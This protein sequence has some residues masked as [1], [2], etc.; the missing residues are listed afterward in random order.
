MPNLNDYLVWRGDISFDAVPVNE[1]DSLIFSLLA[2]I[3]F[4][5]IVPPPHAGG[6][7]LREAAKEYFFVRDQDP[8]RPLGLIVPAEIVVLFR[9]LSEMPR[10]RDLMLSGYVNEICEEREMQFSALTIHLS[11]DA[12]FVAFRG[13]DDTLVGWREDFNLS[14]MDE[15]PSQRKAADYLNDLDLLPDTSLW[16]GGHSKG[17]NLAVWGAVH[18]R[19]SV[20]RCVRRIWSNDG[21][22]F[23]SGTIQSEAYRAMAERISM[24]VPKDSLVGLILEHDEN[25]TVIEST[26]RGLLQH[27]ALSWEVQG[28]SFVRADSLSKRGLRSDT[29]IRDRLDAMTREEKRT[30]VRLFFTVL[31]ST[32]AKTLTDLRRTGLR[33][34]TSML[35]TVAGLSREEQET[36]MYLLGKLF[37][38]AESSTEAAESSK[39]S[40]P[41]AIKTEMRSRI[42]V[43]FG[44]CKRTDPVLS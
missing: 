12:V 14:Y 28:A 34:I 36:G 26:R 35:R 44:F 2:Y 11:E 20:R 5:G 25:F 16:A 15:V 23:S 22:G 27:D 43:E 24:L 17:G 4:D 19:E 41:K 32:G 40:P 10:Y 31:E 13:T 33:A 8:P 30:F 42:V 7:T 21:P 29:V 39:A 9:T 1:V 6:M 18:A 3:D 38:S 37:S